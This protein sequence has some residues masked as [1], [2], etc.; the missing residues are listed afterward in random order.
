MLKMSL[1]SPAHPRRAETRRFPVGQRLFPMVG[2]RRHFLPT[3]PWRLLPTSLLD[4]HALLKILVVEALKAILV[5][6]T[7][8]VLISVVCLKFSYVADDIW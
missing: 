3:C 8:I 1:F 7:G 6:G 5:R 2:G 4:A